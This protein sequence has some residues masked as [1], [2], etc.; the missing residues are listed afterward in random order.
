M[1]HKI[2]PAIAVVFIAATF[3]SATMAATFDVLADF[4]DSATQPAVG[5]PWTYGTET[6]PGAGFALLPNF[7]NATCS[8]TGCGEQLVGGSVDNYYQDFT[9]SGASVGKVAT[10]NNLT[11]DGSPL[12]IPDDVLIM[13]AGS[14]DYHT[15]NFVVTRFTAPYAETFSISGSFSDLQQA[16][17]NVT[18]VING[19]TPFSSSFD[20][21]SAHQGDIPFLIT[22]VSLAAGGTVD[23][24]VDSLGQQS[25]DAVG[26]T[27]QISTVP[28]PIVGAGLPG[29][30]A[31]VGA[32]LAWWRRRR[33]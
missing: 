3:S 33:I 19:A 26:L 22:N 11:I 6:S 24:V 4:N 5:N 29:L 12:L 10:G 28:G 32:A 31:G 14:A 20:G 27:A 15:T 2:I 23:F 13:L 21:S 1:R 9:F 25:D 30:L 17:V 16:S 18:L 7:G 8:G